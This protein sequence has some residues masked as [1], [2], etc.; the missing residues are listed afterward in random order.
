MNTKERT[1]SAFESMMFVFGEPIDVKIAA[2]A[3]GVDKAEALSLFRELVQEYEEQ[4]RGIRVRETGGR[5]GFVTYEENYDYIR[6]ITTPAKERRLSQAALEALAIV[7]YKQPV[8]KSEIDRIRG[9]KSDRVVEGLAEKEL[10]EERGRSEAIGRPVL[11]GTT[12]K[13]LEYFDLKDLGELPE[14]DDD[15]LEEAIRDF[16]TYGADEENDDGA[17]GQT[18]LELTEN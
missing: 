6:T 9:I 2:A 18:K 16:G 7:A 12:G 15:A 3:T 11:F 5:F 17:W 1:K 8:T 4:A 10:I 13:F 14:L